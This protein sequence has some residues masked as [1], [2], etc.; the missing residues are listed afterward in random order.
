MHFLKCDLG[1]LSEYQTYPEKEL[2]IR[3]AEGDESAFALLVQRH[4]PRL[5]VFIAG[6]TKNDSIT[7]DL[8]Q[9]TFIRVWLNKELLPQLD[10]PIFWMHRIASNLTLSHYRRNQLEKK[11]LCEVQR[12]SIVGDLN[13]IINARDL[14][15][16]IQEAIMLLPP[17]RRKIFN[18]IKE[19]GLSR[20]DAAQ[21]LGI[22]ENT[23]KKQLGIAVQSIQ[24]HIR[25]MT[26][27]YIPLFL[28]LYDMKSFF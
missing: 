18:L 8:I 14:N 5:R 11:I 17:Q 26:G 10:N 4:G 23:V 28:L 25:S 9:E 3:I 15:A 12:N 22:S 20:R 21:K 24:E 19:Q 6:M 2:L 13:E 27:L 7:K 16:S 1:L